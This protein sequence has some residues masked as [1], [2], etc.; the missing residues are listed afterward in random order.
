MNGYYLPI[1][2][3][4]ILIF[5]FI[6]NTILLKLAENVGIRNNDNVIRWASGNKPA[7]GGIGFYTIFLISFVS[8]LILVD[9]NSINDNREL[10][11][12]LVACSLAFLMG[13]ADDA[14]NTRPF[15]KFGIQ[16]ICGVILIWSGIY[17]KAFESQIANIILTLF[18]I[19]AIMNAINLLDNMDGI[20]TITAAFIILCTIGLMMNKEMTDAPQFVLLLGVFTSLIAFLFFNWSPSKMFMGDTGSQFLGLFLGATS[21]QYIWNFEPAVG[22]LFSG[23]SIYLTL[24]VFAL[25]IVDTTVVFVNRIRRGQSP[26]VGGKDHTSHNLS[27]LGLSDSQ[28]GWTYIGISITSLVFIAYATLLVDNWTNWHGMIYGLYFLLLLISFFYITY[29]NRKKSHD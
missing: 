13:L 12:I 9:A 23:K 19:I 5:S 11:G 1:F 17:I 21:I 28:V 27:Y 7:L 8:Y 10:V 29:Y 20:T 26:F 24:L 18:W 3:V 4:G 16:I 6:L 14:Y 22:A 15:L 25:P 2:V